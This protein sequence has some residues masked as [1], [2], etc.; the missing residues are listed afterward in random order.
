MSHIE[1]VS[2]QG[3]RGFLD[4]RRIPLAIG[5]RPVSVCVRGDNGTGKSSVADAVEFF[6]SGDGVIARLGKKDNENQAGASAVVHAKATERKVRT[7]VVFSLSD[8]RSL[9]RTAS[10]SGTAARLHDDVAAILKDAPVPLVMR[11]A[12]MKTFVADT[13]G[14]E[15]YVILSCWLGLERLTNL[16]DALTK[17]ENKINKWNRSD[18]KAAFDKQLEKLTRGAVRQWHPPSAVRWISAELPKAVGAGFT[19][20]SVDGLEA[21]DAKLVEKQSTEES[22]SGTKRYDELANTLGQLNAESSALHRLNRANERCGR[23]SID[24]GIARRETTASELQ[25]VWQAAH[26][27]LESHDASDCPVCGRAFDKVTTRDSVVALLG[28]ALASIERV[29]ACQREVETALRE[30]RP[31][32][33]TAQREI[34][35]IASL[36]SDT[37]DPKLESLGRCLTELLSG[38][39]RLMLAVEG[40]TSIAGDELVTMTKSLVATTGRAVKYCSTA[41][42]AL[43]TQVAVPWAELLVSVRQLIAIRDGWM[44]AHREEE[45]LTVV[46]QQFT[47]IADAIRSRVRAHVKSMVAGLE[48]D[49]RTIYSA[50][51]ANDEHVPVIDVVVAEDKKSM[52]LTVSVYGVSEVAPSG[53][54]SDSQLNSLG[55]AVYLAAVRR[56]NDAFRFV[57]LDDIMSSYDGPH[58]LNLVQVLHGFLG[59]FQVIL[60]T[61]DE[62]FYRDIKNALN[63][64]GNWQFLRL[65]PWLLETGVRVAGEIPPDEEIEKRFRD[66]EMPSVL[67]QLVM[68]QT[69]SWLLRICSDARVDVPLRI[70]RDG[71]PAEATMVQL[72]TAAQTR[73][74]EAD[75]AHPAYAIL[76]GHALLNYARHASSASLAIT[77]GELQTYWKHFT[78]FRDAFAGS[79]QSITK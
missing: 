59:G 6:F 36:V 62:P 7:E 69:E 32:A 27:H 78:A 68:E 58:R 60:T 15:R 31:L 72:W 52:K 43:R 23:T 29:I 17:I 16:Q 75:R 2:I 8:G 65:R 38:I 14:A 61:H 63:S 10:S 19:V 41:A 25:T 55:L 20:S 79:R 49:I 73:F 21:L 34:A 39:D 35:R 64:D 1:S 22:R 76:R 40:R 46:A 13:K 47:M 74:S 12:E 77:A 66:G 5:K 30:L 9:S 57:V 67:A 3:F 56:F 26:D 71:T 24:F 54:L 37:A 50:L 42:D 11:A 4:R 45:E 18:R 70:R 51:R 48:N 28:S 53:Y 33:S 44:T